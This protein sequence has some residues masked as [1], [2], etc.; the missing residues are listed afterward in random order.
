MLI[1][2]LCKLIKALEKRGK[3][4]AN[5]YLDSSYGGERE[6]YL[7]DKLINSRHTEDEERRKRIQR[8]EDER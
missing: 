1:L 4:R 6:E 5:V 7:T 2:I 8:L 3:L